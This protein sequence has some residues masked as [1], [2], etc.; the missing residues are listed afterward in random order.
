VLYISTGEDNGPGKVYQV[1]ENGRVLGIVNLPFTARGMAL[2]RQHGLMCALPRDGGK[3][4]R[5]DET[6]KVT[7]IHSKDE[8]MVHPVDVGIAGE[9]DTMV[10]ADNIA[11]TISAMSAGGGKPKLYRRFEGQKW[12][13]QDMSVAITRDKHVIFGTSGD[14]GI[15]RLAGDDHSAKQDPILPEPGGVAADPAT[16]M[17]AAT[18]PPN[19]IHVFEGE[20]LMKK[21]RL[22]ANKR[23]YRNGLLS[24]G[25]ASSVTV[26]AR[27]ADE[28]IGEVW[29]I[30][31]STED[32]S[33][34]SL[35]PWER[36]RMVDFVIGP[37]MFWDRNERRNPNS[38]Y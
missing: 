38:I 23:L 33:V 34:R 28:K 21:F 5:I 3:L 8:K 24:F 1:D 31:Y 25:P 26:A 12:D 18:Q 16:L 19:E 14:K 22:P 32:G 37:R 10:V 27:P 15:Y 35:F 7:T 20:E 6:G 17:W 36:E 30:M 11:D 4:M 2:H 13:A 29:L 9:S